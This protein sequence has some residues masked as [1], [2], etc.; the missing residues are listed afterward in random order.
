[1]VVAA[2]TTT[3]W[4]RRLSWVLTAESSRDQ[5]VEEPDWLLRVVLDALLVI[6]QKV[7]PYGYLQR[8]W[9]DSGRRSADFTPVY[10]LAW[11]AVLAT[12]Y[13][14][15]PL[16]VGGSWELAPVLFVA[17]F[18]YVDLTVW[19]LALL[20]RRTHRR[21]APVE[22]NV[23]L[24]ILDGFTLVFVAAIFLR[25]A[26]VGSSATES[27]FD[28]FFLMTL[29]DV[30]PRTGFWEDVALFAGLS[31][32]LLLIVGGVTIVL[33]TVATRFRSEGPHL[34]PSHARSE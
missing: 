11:L 12:T 32:G 18:R 7:V 25:A 6:T 30:P 1:L 5:Y 28:A 3:A 29:T 26:G 24:L 15:S 33:S 9:T 22:R 4:P 20:L 19:Y 10:T 34:G 17:A 31:S 8:R 16:W 27:W 13:G 21:F 2:L 14:L 23:L